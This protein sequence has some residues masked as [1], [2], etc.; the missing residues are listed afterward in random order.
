MSYCLRVFSL[1]IA[2]QICLQHFGS[3]WG[4]HLCLESLSIYILINNAFDIIWLSQILQTAIVSTQFQLSFQNH[5]DKKQIKFKYLL[6]C[7]ICET[8]FAIAGYIGDVPIILA[9]PQTFMNLSGE[10]VSLLSWESSDVMMEWDRSV[11]K[12]SFPVC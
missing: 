4:L 10:S 7:T 8:C 3:G 1:W 11:E 6:V 12:N 9:K 5:G 2:F